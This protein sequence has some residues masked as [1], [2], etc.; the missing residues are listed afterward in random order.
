M[1]DG[2]PKSDFSRDSRF[3]ADRPKKSKIPEP[4]GPGQYAVQ[5][6][7]RGKSDSKKRVNILD[8]IAQPPARS[9]YY[10]FYEVFSVDHSVHPGRAECCS[11]RHQQIEADQ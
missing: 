1:P 9:I 11:I 6:R 7:W 5:G 2:K 8:R 4:P 10:W 3:E